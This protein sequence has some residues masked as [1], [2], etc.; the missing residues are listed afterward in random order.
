MV[1]ILIVSACGNERSKMLAASLAFSEPIDDELL[2]RPRLDLYPIR[3]APVGAEV[4]R[5]LIYPRNSRLNNFESYT[6]TRAI[7]RYCGI[8]F[9]IR[10]KII[11][12]GL[13]YS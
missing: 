10:L 11:R 12:L 4:A 5:D 6:T 8:L 13:S 9:T 1:K 2:L 3:R 7:H